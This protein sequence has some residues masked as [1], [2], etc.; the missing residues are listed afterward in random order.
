MSPYECEHERN[1]WFCSKP[2]HGL[3]L[4]ALILLLSQEQ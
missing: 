4:S 3:K 2:S 1:Q